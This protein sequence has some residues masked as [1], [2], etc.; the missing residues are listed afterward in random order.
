MMAALSRASLSNDVLH[1]TEVIVFSAPIASL[2][3]FLRGSLSGAGKFSGEF[4]LELSG[5]FTKA[6]VEEMV[7]CLPTSHP[8]PAASR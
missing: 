7:E 6:K 4:S 1:D 5:P 8:A 3:T 2:P